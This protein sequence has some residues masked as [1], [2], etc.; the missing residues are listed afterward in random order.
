MPIAN[1][2][3]KC[4]YCNKGILIAN[5]GQILWFAC[6]RC[7]SQFIADSKR[8]QDVGNI[9]IHRVSRE[10]MDAEGS[11]KELELEKKG[12]VPY[13]DSY[14]ISLGQLEWLEDLPA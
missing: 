3:T 13:T 8:T 11:G 12:V 14:D 2:K 6:G 9:V 4:P 1:T 5:K 10:Y 7:N